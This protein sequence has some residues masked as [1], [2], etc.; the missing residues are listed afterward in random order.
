M[1]TKEKEQFYLYFGPVDK[2]SVCAQL[3]YKPKWIHRLLMRVFF[4]FHV[5]SDVGYN[6]ALKQ[7]SNEKVKMQE[8]ARYER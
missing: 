5:V 4:G 8:G 7:Q 3:S 2:Y 1:S 6:E